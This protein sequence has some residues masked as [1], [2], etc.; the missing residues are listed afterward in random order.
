[1]EDLHLAAVRDFHST[2]SQLPYISGGHLLQLLSHAEYWD[3][4]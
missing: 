1:M 2:Y 3:D 4:K